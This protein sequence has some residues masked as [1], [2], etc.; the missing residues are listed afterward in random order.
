MT[1]TISGMAE[2]LVNKRPMIVIAGAPDSITDGMGA[3]QELD[4][5][6]CAKPVTKYAARASSVAHI[7]IVVERAVKMA[8][9]GTPGPTYV[10][11]TNDILYAKVPESQITY[12]P[13]VEPLQPLVLPE[14]IVSRVIAKLQ[15]AKQPL[16]IVGKGVAYGRAE[17]VM[18][19][20]VERT[21]IPF[22]ATPMGKG[23]VSDYDS[24][25]AG[26][27]RTFVL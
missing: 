9:Y 24:H 11:L 16:I 21:N 10:E 7:P 5:L 14:V 4:Q 3:F 27:A 20:F 25:S 18:R 26:S 13:K 1:N 17:D 8:L 15:G 19:T 22:L 23:A 2:A 6:A 12:R